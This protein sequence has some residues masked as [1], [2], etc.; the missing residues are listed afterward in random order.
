MRATPLSGSC[1]QVCLVKLV[2]SRCNGIVVVF[3]L[4]SREQGS[5]DF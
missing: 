4:L 3:L 2:L 5:D 1:L